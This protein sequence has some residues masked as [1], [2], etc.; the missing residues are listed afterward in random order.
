VRTTNTIDLI[1]Q[2][3]LKGVLYNIMTLINFQKAL[4][5]LH[6]GIVELICIALDHWIDWDS[7][8]GNEGIAEFLD[9]NASL[10]G[11]LE[12]RKDIL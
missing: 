5:F 11:I 6:K 7:F 2:L 9:G 4:Y 1:G 3:T 10:T 12:A 8:K